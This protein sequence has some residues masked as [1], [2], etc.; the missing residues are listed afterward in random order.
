[1][2]FPSLQDL[3]HPDGSVEQDHAA[4]PGRR[5]RSDFSLGSLAPSLAKRRALSRAIKASRPQRT[6]AVLFATPVNLA[7]FFS[8]L[9]SIFT[10]V[11][12]LTLLLKNGTSR[13]F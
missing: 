5:R 3:V 11:L 8:S 7:A 6:S 9:R 13:T 1:M 10:V 4:E 2:R 12:I